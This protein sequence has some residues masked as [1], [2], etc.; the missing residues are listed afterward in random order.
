M[1][2]AL[3]TGRGDL[4]WRRIATSFAREGAK[5]S[6]TGLREEEYVCSLSKT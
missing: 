3:V 2:V 1:K 5:V 4:G 6:I